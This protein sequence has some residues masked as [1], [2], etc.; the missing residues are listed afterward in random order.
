MR[1]EQ[2]AEIT[3]RIR[4]SLDM[5]SVLHIAMNEIAQRLGISQIEIQLGS[6]L[7]APEENPDEASKVSLP[8]SQSETAGRSP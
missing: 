2:S 3:A 1:E 4:S 5:E 6:E 7:A 8:R